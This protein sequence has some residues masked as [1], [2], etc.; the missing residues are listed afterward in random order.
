MKTLKT[1]LAVLMVCTALMLP[2]VV[3]ATM[4]IDPTSSAAANAVPVASVKIVTLNLDSTEIDVNGSKI[5]MDV[6]PTRK[7][8]FTYIPLRYAAEAVGAT[9]SWSD[10]DR[11]A[12]VTWSGLS[13]TFAVGS[14]VVMINGEKRV[15]SAVL[16]M[17]G[18]R[19]M[20]PVQIFAEVTGWTADLAEEGK[21]IRLLSP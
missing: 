19:L 8:N 1:K 3:G 5:V 11:E 10:I 7:D 18:E 20:V 16:V 13:A 9:L 17:Q 2:S 14:D 6:Y 4:V 15:A 12:T 21:V